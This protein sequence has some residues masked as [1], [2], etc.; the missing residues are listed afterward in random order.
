MPKRK[1]TYTSKIKYF[2]KVKPKQVDSTVK[3][4]LT[5][6]THTLVSN[7]KVP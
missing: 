7:T 6:V 4:N 1:V 2:D 5:I 3:G